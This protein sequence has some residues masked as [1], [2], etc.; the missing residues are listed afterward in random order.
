MKTIEGLNFVPLL[1]K[2]IIQEKVLSL[3]QE[4]QKDLRDK[5]PVVL[6]VLNGSFMFLADLVK[7]FDFECQ[8]SFLKISS[9]KNL[10]STG[11]VKELIGLDIDLTDREIL[12]V[13][14]II[15]TGK[16]MKWLLDHLKERNV[17]NVRIASLLKKPDALQT[18][19]AVDY[20]GF[21]IPNDFVIGYGLDYNGYARNWDEIYILKPST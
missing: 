20:C 19:I 9:Y 11:S 17:R 5:N 7:H 21:E 13:E 3:A 1:T 10:S 14:D 15:D 2:Q 4:I 6:A 12:I 18:P 16:T 8:V